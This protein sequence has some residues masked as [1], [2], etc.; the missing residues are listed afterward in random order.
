[1]RILVSNDDGIHAP[2]IKALV[3][4]LKK[5]HEVTVVAPEYEQSAVGHAITIAN[6]L[7]VQEVYDN[8]DFFGYAINGTPADCIKIAIKS[9][10]DFEPDLVVSGINLGGNY[11]KNI[12]YSGTVSAA[13]EGCILGIR[14]IAFS[15]NTFINPDF[16]PSAQFALEMLDKVKDIEL[17]DDV[18]LNINVP[19]VKKCEIVG[20]KVVKQGKSRFIEDFDKRK[21]PRG[22]Y[23][24]WMA[25]EMET[26][27]ND[28][29]TDYWYIKENY[30][31]I[32]PIKHDLTDYLTLETIKH[33]EG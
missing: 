16:S 13:T 14:S 32:T 19:A 8:K 29:E 18:L 3:A 31:T 33:F 11:A 5:K 26:G 25:G 9:I 20:V 2:G 24:Y 27:E 1:M 4:E 17:P 6:P 28:L 30:I 12:I 22:N 10:L 7:R 21:D 23:Y 15:L